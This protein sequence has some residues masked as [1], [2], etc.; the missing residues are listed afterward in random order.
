MTFGCVLIL[1]MG[2]LFVAQCYAGYHGISHHWG[3][4]WAIAA[5]VLAFFFQFTLPIT[6][7]SYFGAIYLWHWPWYGALAFATPGMA[8]M[9]LAMIPGA[10]AGLFEKARGRNL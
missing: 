5:I 9:L 4:E 2:A 3:I 10:M 1:G 8:L 6:V 7:G